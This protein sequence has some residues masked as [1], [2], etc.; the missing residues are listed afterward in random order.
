MADIRDIQHLLSPG[1]QPRRTTILLA[2]DNPQTRDCLTDILSPHH[3]VIACEDG[4][5]ALSMARNKSPDLILS[6]ILMPRLDGLGLLKALRAEPE[7]SNIPLIFL[8]GRGGD[9]SS[10]EGLTAGAD[11]YVVKPCLPHDLLTRIDLRLQR[12]HAENEMR[13]NEERLKL[14]IQFTPAAIAMFDRQMRY[15]AA[16]F[17]FLRDFNVTETEIVGRSHYEI[18]PEIPEHWREFHSRAQRGE[19]LRVEEDRFVRGDGTIQWVRWE[20]HPWYTHEGAVGGIILFTEDITARKEAEEKTR[21][22]EERYRDLSEELARSNK[23]LEFFTSMASH[24]LR[25]PLRKIQTFNERLRASSPALGENEKQYFERI[26]GTISRMNDLIRNLLDYSKLSGDAKYFDLVDLDEV[27]QEALSDLELRIADCKAQI[28]YHKLPVTRANRFQMRQ[29]FQNLLSNSLKY[30]CKEGVPVIEITCET[31]GDGYTIYFKDNGIGFDERFAEQ[32]FSPFQRLHAHS[33]YEGVGMG[34]AICE[35]IARH[36][37]GRIFA[38]SS[39]GKGSTFII[40][41]PQREPSKAL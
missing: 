5:T 19:V 13:A 33:E 30:C 25:E 26:A 35:K 15:L 1:V 14:F 6:D 20:L 3:D 8:S 11:D 2:E 10:L 31:T 12:K 24:D 16:S 39:I 21:R 23:E 27:L 36:H 41:I 7:L 32:I 17:R 29:L 28:T 38:K 40:E 37:G 4:L 34:L 18:F 22:S 9:E